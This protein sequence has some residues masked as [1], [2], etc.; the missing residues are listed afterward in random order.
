MDREMWRVEPVLPGGVVLAFALLLA[1]GWL[2][3]FGV[4]LLL[5]GIPITVRREYLSLPDTGHAPE[6]GEL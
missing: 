1:N 3:L 6:G 5:I 4:A 2:S